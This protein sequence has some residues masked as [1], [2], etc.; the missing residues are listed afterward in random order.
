MKEVAK[1]MR[2]L[3]QLELY[4]ENLVRTVNC[5]VIPVV[6]YVMNVCGLSKEGLVEHYMI[7]YWELRVRNIHGRQTS[8]KSLFLARAKGGRG[9]KSMRDM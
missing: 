3:T 2:S 1:S 5:R 8:D 4:D 6:G 7:V 9:V